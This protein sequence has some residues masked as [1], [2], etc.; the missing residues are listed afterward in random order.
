MELNDGMRLIY[1]GLLLVFVGGGFFLYRRVGLG[2]IA[3]GGL[4]WL[5]IFLVVIAAYGIWDERTAPNA[6]NIQMHTSD[7]VIEIPRARD[8]HFYLALIINGASVP[9]LVDTGATEL[10]L[11]QKD[12]ARVGLD[13]ATL[14]YTGRARTANGETRTAP[15]RL[16]A[17]ALGPVTDTNVRAW[18]N[19]GQMDRSLL[20][21]SYLQRWTRME[22]TRDAL[23]LTR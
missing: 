4:G 12:A 9:M 20:G 14:A 3:R 8:G 21:M 1:L 23:I 11:T 10:V 2:Q 17:V 15:V 6:R 5:V 18:V 13:P 19:E 22:I 7:N 16:D